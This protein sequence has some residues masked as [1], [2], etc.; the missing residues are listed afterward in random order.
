MRTRKSVT[1][2][3]QQRPSIAEEAK[4]HDTLMNS[5]KLSA[6]GEGFEC[7]CKYLTG[8][9]TYQEIGC[10]RR[11]EPCCKGDTIITTMRRRTETPAQ[12]Q[13]L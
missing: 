7:M 3:K 5:N 13:Y 8:C 10:N 11:R 4:Q 6:E 1:Q 12:G 2:R 9:D